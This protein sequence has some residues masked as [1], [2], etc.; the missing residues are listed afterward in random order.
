MMKTPR[1]I[2]GTVTEKVSAKGASVTKTPYP[3]DMSDYHGPGEKGND[4]PV[5]ADGAAGGYGASTK[6]AAK[7]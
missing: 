6:R 4:M 3:K 1:S 5:V 2:G 7:S